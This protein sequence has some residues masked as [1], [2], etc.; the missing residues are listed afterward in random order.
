MRGG[1][2]L[3]NGYL[4]LERKC[5]IAYGF[6]VEKKIKLLRNGI[7]LITKI[8]TL[9]SFLEFSIVIKNT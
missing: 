7:N 3:D 9:L 5:D 8:F 6:H 4:E 2:C 1:L